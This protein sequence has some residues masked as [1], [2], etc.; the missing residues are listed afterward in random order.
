MYCGTSACFYRN[1]SRVKYEFQIVTIKCMFAGSSLLQKP[2]LHLAVFHMLHVCVCVCASTRDHT[3]ARLPSPSLPRNEEWS[4]PLQW[5]KDMFIQLL[6]AGSKRRKTD[7]RGTLVKC[8]HNAAQVETH[9]KRCSKSASRRLVL[10]ESAKGK[11]TFEFTNRVISS[12]VDLVKPQED[13]VCLLWSIG[14][15]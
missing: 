8:Q 15:S 4:I 14:L 3:A 13:R 10:S 1:Q 9:I 6:L 2:L 7:Y 5:R 11:Q 12:V